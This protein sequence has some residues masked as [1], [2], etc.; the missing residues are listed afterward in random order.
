MLPALTLDNRILAITQMNEEIHSK[1][2]CNH[3]MSYRRF[4][5]KNRMFQFR[6]R[7]HNDNAI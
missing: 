7:S 5:T 2:F 1:T 4:S 6:S 3:M